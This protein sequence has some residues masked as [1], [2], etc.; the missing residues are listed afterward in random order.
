MTPSQLINKLCD[1]TDSDVIKW[2]GKSCSQNGAG[3]TLDSKTDGDQRDGYWTVYT[4]TIKNGTTS[5][6]KVDSSLGK[7]LEKAIDSQSRRGKDRETAQKMAFAQSAI[8]RMTAP[9]C[10]SFMEQR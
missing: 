6:V 4:L 8:D 1:L 9:Q 2:N 5:F 3:F 10:V 7:Q